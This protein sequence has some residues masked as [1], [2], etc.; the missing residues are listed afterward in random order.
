MRGYEDGSIFSCAG[1]NRGYTA[2]KEPKQ[3][4]PLTFA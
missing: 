1:Y 2:T 4:E 3:R